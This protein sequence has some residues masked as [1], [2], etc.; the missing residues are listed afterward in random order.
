MV[1]VVSI[2]PFDFPV[3]ARHAHYRLA[4]MLVH[5]VA[6]VLAVTAS[7]TAAA[8]A[9]SA[10]ATPGH[11]LAYAMIMT[12]SFIMSLAAFLGARSLTPQTPR[13]AKVYLAGQRRAVRVRLRLDLDLPADTY[14]AFQR[15]RRWEPPDTITAV[16]VNDLSPGQGLAFGPVVFSYEQAVK[17]FLTGYCRAD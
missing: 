14:R 6:L 10:P 13:R 7:F 17:T 4:S 11:L 15:G 12:S 3:R 16:S 2:N 8:T 5:L 1:R 9:P